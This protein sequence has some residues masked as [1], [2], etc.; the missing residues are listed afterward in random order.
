MTDR[1]DGPTNQTIDGRTGGSGGGSYSSNN[2]TVVK[3]IEWM[4]LRHC[5]HSRCPI[6]IVRQAVIT[7]MN[8]AGN[9]YGTAGTC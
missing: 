8:R 2:R 1:R 5:L 9:E 7:Y 3:L 4:D 6:I